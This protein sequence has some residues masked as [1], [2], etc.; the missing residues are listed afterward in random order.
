MR[1]QHPSNITHE[2]SEQI[3]RLLE[4]GWKKTAPRKI[5]LY[6][7]FCAILYLLKSGCCQKFFPNG[8]PSTIILAYGTNLW[9]RLHALYTGA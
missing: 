2:Q 3:H 9:M 7:I 6:E 5:E 4:S 8:I 1:K